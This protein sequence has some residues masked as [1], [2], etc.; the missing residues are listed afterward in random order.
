MHKEQL[1]APFIHQR[2]APVV[3]RI[4]DKQAPQRCKASVEVTRNVSLEQSKRVVGT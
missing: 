3:L 4:G 2:L 1:V